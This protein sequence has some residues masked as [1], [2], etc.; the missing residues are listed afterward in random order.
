MQFS[1]PVIAW[2]F[3]ALAGCTQAPL[4][5]QP[6]NA[7][8]RAH[9]RLNLTEQSLVSGFAKV[10]KIDGPVVCGEAIP[11]PQTVFLANRGIALATDI[12]RDGVWIP[13]EERFTFT[14]ISVLDGWPACGLS[15][16]FKPRKLGSYE[17]RINHQNHVSET[18]AETC[19][20]EVVDVTEVGAR[21]DADFRPE[22]CLPKDASK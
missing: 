9:L 8:A 1:T 2:A 7:Q 11:N 16:S 22:V 12:N 18:N 5:R 6:D 17:L 21:D 3:I 14:A 20:V 19:T 15:A 13:A 10:Y 4:Y